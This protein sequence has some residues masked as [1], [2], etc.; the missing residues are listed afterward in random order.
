M[1]VGGKCVIGAL[2][3]SHE[4]DYACKRV[5]L[6]KLTLVDSVTSRFI[7]LQVVMVS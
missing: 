2:R 7:M 4:V 3:S 1:R 5:I 6:E